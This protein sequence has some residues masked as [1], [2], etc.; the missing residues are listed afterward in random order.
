MMTVIL[1][2]SI[3]AEVM[4]TPTKSRPPTQPA[5]TSVST[6]VPV[7]DVTTW[8]VSTPS[9]VLFIIPAAVVFS[10]ITVEP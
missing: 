6:V 5:S 1:T 2:Q 10:G 9:V 4:T 8:V 7:S 3:T